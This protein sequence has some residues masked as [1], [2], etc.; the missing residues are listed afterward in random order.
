[1]TFGI[2]WILGPG[3]TPARAEFVMCVGGQGLVPAAS[4]VVPPH[5]RIVY[6]A[7]QNLSTPQNISAQIDGTAVAVKKTELRARPFQVLVLEID[8]PRT[9]AL[10]VTFDQRQPLRWTVKA[11]TMPKDVTG[12]AARYQGP[13]HP[14][15]PGEGF[16]GLAIRLP[17]GTPAVMS[18]VKVRTEPDAALWLET[19]V[20]I[21]TAASES[22]P[23]IRVGQFD[24]APNIAPSLLQHGFDLEVTV[25]LSD[26]T[27]RRVS[28][29]AP[30]MSLPAPL[31]P[32]PRPKNQRLP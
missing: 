27:T 31:P 18:H 23:M 9:G 24:C 2:L 16:D 29:L 17:E 26:G 21:Y 7:D 11:I 12:V 19:D 1:M 8:S 4:S 25:T 3:A 28:G 14:G 6:Y 20:P 5:A 30:H 22:R 13:A 15:E 10:V 32:Q